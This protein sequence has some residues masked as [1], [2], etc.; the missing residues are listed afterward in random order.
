MIGA[1][2]PS[3]MKCELWDAAVCATVSLEILYHGP[4][5][6]WE[7]DVVYRKYGPTT[8]GDAGTADWYML[9]GVVFDITTVTGTPTARASFK[10]VDGELGDDTSVD[11]EIVDQG[12]PGVPPSDIPINDG[13]GSFGFM[14]LSSRRRVCRWMWKASER[15][16]PGS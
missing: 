1:V 3:T 16:E 5:A 6:R 11:G 13:M 2:T 15:V 9:P 14:W 12:G 4:V 7:S 8:P 10:L